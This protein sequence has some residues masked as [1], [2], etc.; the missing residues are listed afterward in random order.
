MYGGRGTYGTPFTEGGNFWPGSIGEAW[1]YAYQ[2][3]DTPDFALA[4]RGQTLG[5]R[6]ARLY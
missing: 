2:H 6:S 1:Q 3:P 4:Q 5:S